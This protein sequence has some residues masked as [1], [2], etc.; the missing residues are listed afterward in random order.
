MGAIRTGPRM[1]LLRLGLSRQAHLLVTQG[2]SR[3]TPNQGRTVEDPFLVECSRTG[4]SGHLLSGH[5]LPATDQSRSGALGYSQ[6]LLPRS[7]QEGL[8]G[9]RSFVVRASATHVLQNSSVKGMKGRCF[10]PLDILLLCLILFITS[11]L[12]FL[13]GL[14]ASI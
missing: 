4:P 10:I 8:P 9:D 2:H 3:T 12:R 1:V 14:P 7:L 5:L 6:L 13:S 11:Q